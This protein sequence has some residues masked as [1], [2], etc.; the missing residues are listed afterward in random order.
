MGR[1]WKL[2]LTGTS[3]G[4]TPIDDP[5]T[6]RSGSDAFTG[7]VS[8]GSVTLTFPEGLGAVQTWVGSLSGNTLTLS[9]TSS[10]GSIEV[11]TYQPGTVADYNAAVTQVQ[12][13]VQQALDAIASAN[14]ANAAATASAA[15][16]SAEPRNTSRPSFPTL[17]LARR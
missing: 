8:G 2:A 7:T 5:T 11:D 15:A 6:M 4:L 16:A 3:T 13:Q 9:F 1:E 12:A 17:R 14:A 10:D